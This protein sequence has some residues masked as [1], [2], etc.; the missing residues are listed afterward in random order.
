MTW[1]RR[2]GFD[3]RAE[4]ADVHVDQSTITEVAVPPHLI[5][6]FLA[7]EDP[8]RILGE[9]TEQTEFGLREMDLLSGPDDLAF[10]GT[11]SRSPN[12]SRG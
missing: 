9:F 7:A 4:S 3:L 12:T 5:E 8:S 11:I 1:I 6:E 10:V 2:V